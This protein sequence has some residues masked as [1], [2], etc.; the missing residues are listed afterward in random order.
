MKQTLFFILSLTIVT[1]P[2][3]SPAADV[4]RSTSI[5]IMREGD[6][7]F[8]SLDPKMLP[9]DTSPQLFQG[10]LSGNSFDIFVRDL[11][12]QSVTIELGFVDTESKGAQERTFSVSA[13]GTPLDAN[14]DV[15]TKAGGSFKPWVMKTTYAHP[16]GALDIQFAGLSKPAFVSY[17][18]VIDANGKAIA[19]GTASDWKN[20]ERIKL[21]DSR[22]RPFRHVKVGEVPFFNVDHSPVGTW[23][24]FVYGMEE[25][26]GVQ[27]CKWGGG[28]MTLIPDQG[29]IIAVKNGRTERVMPFACKQ[30]SLSKT[31]I[32]SDKEVTR[33]L[34]ACTDDWTIPMGVSWTHYTPVWQMKD[35][36]TASNEEKRRFVLPVTW[37][38]YRIDN[39]SGKD[40]TRL[41]FSLQQPAVRAKGWTGFD[42][43]VVEPSSSI[44]VK[45]GDA[46]LLTQEQVK[47]NFG[48]DGATSAF[49]VHVP[50]GT[51]KEVTFYIA[52]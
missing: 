15:R 16:G 39:R 49:C 34:G 20:G 33:K 30:T 4:F 42:G 12:A 50:A 37:M 48:I 46:E 41:L 28:K 35:W 32:I 24:T 9:P 38:Q 43:Y 18:R 1:A 22:S 19:F 27:V 45:T 6:A 51:Q 44:A 26:G 3:A 5:H 47:Q 2:F 31:A 11:P 10:V 7:R 52:Q 36:G 14:L 8:S 40:E 17:A 13:N 25:S 29:V 23:S 21:V